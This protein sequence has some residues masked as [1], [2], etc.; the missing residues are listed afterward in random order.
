MKFSF[1][2]L[3]VCLSQF[4]YGQARLVNLSLSDSSRK[5]LYIGVENHLKLY[6]TKDQT[7]III[8]IYGGGILT[9][10]GNNEYIV[11]ASATG[12]NSIRVLQDGKQILKQEFTVETLAP[13]EVSVGF[14]KDSVATVDEILKNPLLRIGFPNNFYRHQYSVVSFVASL[15]FA[16]N[17]EL[18]VEFENIGSQFSGEL[19][20]QIKKLREGDYVTIHN[21]RVT[22]PG[23]RTRKLV[24]III[25]VK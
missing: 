5:I 2:I 17:K 12:I 22:C 15:A 1:S 18:D 4:L 13:I 6:G 24:P 3:L 14:I 23:C 21:I 7:H 8:N 9:I 19:I 25:L 16:A 20:E 11:K 10:K